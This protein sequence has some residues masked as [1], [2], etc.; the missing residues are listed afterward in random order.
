MEIFLSICVGIGLSAAC[1]FRVFVPLLGISVA[2]V[3]GHLKLAAGFEWIGTWPALACFL[4]ATVAEVAAYYVPWIDNLLDTIAT[5]AAVVAG[6]IATASVVTDMSP[7]LRWSLAI[8]AGGG[9]AALVQTG[10]VT[11]RGASTATTGGLANFAVS[12]GELALSTTMTVVAFMLP[13]LAAGCVLVL[14]AVAVRV[15][16]KRR[17]RVARIETPPA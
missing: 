7:L 17:T 14:V 10:T 15:F 1:G 4:T 6:T 13:I 3:A 11:L 8:I 12:T 16:L 9:V 5:P 2:A